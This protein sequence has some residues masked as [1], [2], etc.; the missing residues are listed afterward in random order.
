MS[1]LIIDFMFPTP[2]LVYLK[3]VKLA[4]LLRLLY[5]I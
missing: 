4:K 5:K 2:N 1:K 3:Q